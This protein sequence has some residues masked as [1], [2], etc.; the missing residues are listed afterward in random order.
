MNN[1]EKEGIISSAF[2]PRIEL[3]GNTCCTVE[4][5]RSIPVYNSETIKLNLGKFSVSFFG[6]GLF[7]RAFTREGAQLG[8]IIVSMEFESNG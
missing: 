7:I 5:I 1:T 2:S 3:E 8:G 6:D 4:G